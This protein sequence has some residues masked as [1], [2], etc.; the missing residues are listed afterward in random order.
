LRASQPA[1]IFT[2]VAILISLA[3]LAHSSATDP[4]W[5]PGVWDDAD[6]DDVVILATSNCG[7]ADD[8]RPGQPDFLTLVGT[9]TDGTAGLLAAY[10][11]PS[12]RPRAPPAV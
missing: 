2:T 1:L 5:V 10:P 3:P 9:I 7:L 6:Q 12:V 4:T 11:R 8:S